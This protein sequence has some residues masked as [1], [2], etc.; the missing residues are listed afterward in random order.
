MPRALWGLGCGSTE[1]FFI[2]CMSRAL[3]R[4]LAGKVYRRFCSRRQGPSLVEG[5]LESVSSD[6]ELKATQ[7]TACHSK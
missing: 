3:S 2:W 6:K 4:I 1:R 5:P 7:P